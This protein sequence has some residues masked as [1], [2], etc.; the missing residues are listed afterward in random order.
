MSACGECLRVD[1][2]PLKWTFL[3]IICPAPLGC[4]WLGRMEW[5]E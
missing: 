1:N 4:V 3:L 2:S 5:N